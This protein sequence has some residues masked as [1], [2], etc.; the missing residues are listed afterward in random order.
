[1]SRH[2]VSVDCW[3]KTVIF[4]PDGE[5]EF[6]F[7]GDGLSSPSSILSAI[8]RRMVRKGMQGFLAYVHDVNIEVPMMD[9]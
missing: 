7:H 1:M 6:A 9:Q 3:N 4:K 5:T 2:D 8:T